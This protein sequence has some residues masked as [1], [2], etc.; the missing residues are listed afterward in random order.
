MPH[1]DGQLLIH[2]D[3]GPDTAGQLLDW[4][5]GDEGLRGRAHLQDRPVREGDM[6]AVSEVVTVAL[7]SGATVGIVASLARSLTTWLTNR[8]SDVTV[9]V[10]RPGGDSVEFSG[11]RVDAADVLRRIQD[12]ADS[13]D[14]PQ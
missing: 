2:T 7:G 12:L 10:T 13:T 8:R 1:A 14:A 11:K 6:G 3:D 9:T 5:S 4:L